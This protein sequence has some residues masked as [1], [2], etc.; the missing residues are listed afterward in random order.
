MR[1]PGTLDAVADLHARLLPDGP[2]LDEKDKQDV[3]DVLFA[4]VDLS[5]F[6]E[7]I[8]GRLDLASVE[9]VEYVRLTIEASFQS[10]LDVRQT[11]ASISDMP[12][13]CAIGWDDACRFETMMV[14]LAAGRR[15]L[16]EG[17]ASVPERWSAL[18]DLA[19]LA[20]LF[21]ARTY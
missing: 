17:S 20:L 18:L 13:R 16:A 14:E 15:R 5:F 7:S 9:D 3:Y 19:K 2:G 12:T 1:Q 4:A 11:A 10:F 21:V 8:G 6:L